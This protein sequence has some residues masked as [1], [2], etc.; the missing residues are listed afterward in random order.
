MS[1]KKNE[2][3]SDDSSDDESKG[4]YGTNP[5][6]VLIAACGAVR[7]LSRSV[8]VLRTT[9]ID[10]GV[11]EPVFQLLQHPEIEVQIAATATVCNLLT[12]VSP[13]R[14]PISEAGVLK[15]LCEHARSMNA[16][17]RLNA[18]W[19][20][21]HFVHGVSNDMKRQC[22]EEIGPG[23]LVQLICD[24]TE[25]EALLNSRGRVDRD[26]P[27]SNEMDEDVVMDQFEEQVDEAFGRINS[28]PSS[29]SKSIQQAEARLAALRDAETN[30]ARR[31]RKDDIAV[32]EQ[33]LDFIRNL[34]GG[35]GQ[36]G[37]AETTE[38][39]DFL[40]SAL[41]Q[42]RVFEI[43]ASKLKPKMINPYNRGSPN[44]ERKILPPQAEIIIAVGY[45]LVHMAASVPRHRQ[46]VIAQTDLL[47][48]LVPQFN[49][50]NIEVRLALC[51]L[52]SNLT[53][54]DD[55]N[56]GQACAQRANEL[57]KLGF[58][59]KIEM[60]EQDP[61]LNVRERAKSAIW[62]IRQAF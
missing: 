18:V 60:L 17:L 34:I 15:I 40:F 39:I 61:E 6:E 8:S 55:Q 2:K 20:L 1:K 48:L 26:G 3:T 7:A 11:A 46:I 57:K 29:R 5:V 13:M 44:S 49:H 16:K 54:M 62:Q 35:A 52:V 28:R 53:W 33:G 50:P 45:I 14:E 42:D 59:S 22:L 10:N 9:L 37:T 31:A 12:D 21:K 47:K 51:W 19:S 27:R 23:W 32:Q 25:D 58:L 30:P 41:G 56:D 36:G 43:L 24:D 38:M 4:E